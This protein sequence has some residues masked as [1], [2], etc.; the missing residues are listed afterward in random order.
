VR[1][2]G[3]LVVVI[4]RKSVGEGVLRELALCSGRPVLRTGPNNASAPRGPTPSAH[5]QTYELE[6]LMSCLACFMAFLD[7]DLALAC[8]LHP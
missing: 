7:S 2:N 1:E 6:S 8:G 3:S 4:R 5:K